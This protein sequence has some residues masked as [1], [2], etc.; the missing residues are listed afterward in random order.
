MGE[1][2]VDGRQSERDVWEGKECVYKQTADIAR[3]MERSVSECRFD[4]FPHERHFPL[5]NFHF[6]Q[7][8]KQVKT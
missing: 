7:V 5:E 2:F 1:Q 3:G 6:C 4:I 8:S